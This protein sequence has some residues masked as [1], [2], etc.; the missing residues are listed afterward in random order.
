MKD[1][2]FSVAHND[3]E[4]ESD[5]ATKPRLAKCLAQHFQVWILCAMSRSF[6][7]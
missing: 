1:V 7:G 5:F 6:S 3:V 4:M 2:D